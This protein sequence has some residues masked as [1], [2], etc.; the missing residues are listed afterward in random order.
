MMLSS[1]HRREG[2]RVP[3]VMAAALAVAGSLA[4][5]AQTAGAQTASD[6]AMFHHDAQ[7]T[8]V[9][10]DTTIGVTHATAGLASRWHAKGGGGS[11]GLAAIQ[12][13]P[14]VVYN[15][16]LAKTV[17]YVATTGAPAALRMF[18]AATGALLNNYT[19]NKGSVSTPAVFGNTVYFGDQ[20]HTLYALDATDLSLQCTYVTTGRIQ[21]SPVVD[22]VDG[23]GATVFIGDVGT[24]ERN[25]GGNE[26]AIN[27]VGNTNGPCTLKW[28]FRSWANLGNQGDKTGSWSS[29]A[30]GQDAAGRWLLVMGSSNPDDSVYALDAVTGAQVWRFQ[31]AIN[32]ADQD[33]GAP[34]TISAPGVNGLAD[35]AVYINGK[36]KIEYALDLLTGAELWEF[37]MGTDAGIE[38]NSVSGTALVGGD[39]VVSYATY[40]YELD[41]VTGS[42]V[43]RTPAMASISLASPAVSGA[44]GDQVVIVGDLAANLYAYNLGD[45]SLVW[46]HR[47]NPDSSNSKIIASAAVASG[48]VYIATVNPGKVFGIK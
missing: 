18:D 25:N 41:A 3:V 35:G 9:S 20:D 33:V 45:G 22:D 34:P 38:S 39:V 6:W 27:G 28:K 23:S 5:S 11:H 13:S 29:P 26:W 30:L 42:M 24:N 16:T 17:V 46:Q 19:L 36:D 47:F 44:P 48:M 14:V 12:G 1:A 37:D 2:R 10:P 31:T 43:W 21:A 15:A 40:T 8:G 32:G 4:L 7:H